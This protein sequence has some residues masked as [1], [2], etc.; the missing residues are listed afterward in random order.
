[1]TETATPRLTTTPATGPDQFLTV[2]L[3]I[4]RAELIQARAAATRCPS[5]PNLYAL[6]EARASVDTLLDLCPVLR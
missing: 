1:M 4:A 2:E 3:T 5:T 6:D